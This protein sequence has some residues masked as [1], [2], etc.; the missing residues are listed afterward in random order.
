MNQVQER[1]LAPIR[2]SAHEVNGVALPDAH[3]F[4]TR[5]DGHGCSAESAGGTD[6]AAAFGELVRIGTSCCPL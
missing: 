5:G 3:W 2:R 6:S 1:T 4:K